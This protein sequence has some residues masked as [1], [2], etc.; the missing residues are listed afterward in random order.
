M[1]YSGNLPTRL[2]EYAADQLEKEILWVMTPPLTAPTEA[3]KL[4]AREI[5]ERIVSEGKLYEVIEATM[6]KPCPTCGEMG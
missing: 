5:R 4:K 2:E 3:Q 6:P 1:A